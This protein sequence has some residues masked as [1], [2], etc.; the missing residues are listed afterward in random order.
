MVVVVAHRGASAY[1]PE[2]TLRAVRRAIEMGADAVEV[3]VRLSRD[4]EL[5][6][7][8]DEDLWRV[9]RVKA[10]VRDL[11]LRELRGV[12]VGGGERI[13]T[14]SEVVE[15]VR[16]RAGLIVELKEE[17][18][19]GRVVEVLRGLNGAM[20]TSFIHRSVRRV[21]EIDRSL[22]TG[23]IYTCLPIKLVGLALDADADALLPRRDFVTEELIDEARGHGLKVYAWTVDDEAEAVRL[24]RMGVDGI[25]TNRP[26]AVLR[27]LRGAGLRG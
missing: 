7:V 8:H 16:G 2:N 20:A 4:A 9:S 3:D 24:A 21:K 6:V 27:A 5:V 25:V 13:P 22:A 17:G 26:D 15:A 1:E 11:S 14:L 19:E 23:V 18:F 10:K 12:D